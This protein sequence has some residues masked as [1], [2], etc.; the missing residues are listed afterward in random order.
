MRYLTFLFLALLTILST[1][2][3]TGDYPVTE[4]KSLQ[5]LQAAKQRGAVL[6]KTGERYFVRIGPDYKGPY[7]SLKTAVDLRRDYEKRAREAGVILPSAT[8]PA[9]P[10]E[11]YFNPATMMFPFVEAQ[12]G[13]GIFLLVPNGKLT[14]APSVMIHPE[15]LLYDEIVFGALD[16]T[17]PQ[18]RPQTAPD[19]PAPPHQRK[20]FF[21]VTGRVASK[22][23][24]DFPTAS[25]TLSVGAAVVASDGE[26][27]WKQYGAV[28]D[29]MSFRILTPM[30]QT[31]RVPQYLLLFTVGEGKLERT[32]RPS[33]RYPSIDA[34]PYEY[35]ILCSAALEMGDNWFPP[36]MEATREEYKTLMEKEKQFGKRKP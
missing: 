12:P 25:L 9:E 28:E 29:D 24:I 4:C 34:A 7:A 27:I 35:H 30:P 13:K 5:E 31:Q 3:Q 33:E 36:L 6:L 21:A 16:M 14:S 23:T 2:A 20:I 10:N 1:N 11:A 15:P 26:V 19:Q 18:L 8:A 22:A 17:P 32:L